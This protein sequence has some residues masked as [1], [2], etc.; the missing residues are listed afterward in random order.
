MSE[1]E[2]KPVYLTFSAHIDQF[3]VQRFFATIAGAMHD[4]FTEAH[5]LMQ[6]IGGNVADGVCLYNYFKS[7]PIEISIYNCGSISSAGVTAY[8]GGD[9]R[10][11]TP[12]GTFMIHRASAVFQGANSDAVQAR[13]PSLIMDDERTEMILRECIELTDEQ[14]SVHKA[15]DLWLNANGALDAKIATEIGSFS[16][17]YEAK[18]FNVLP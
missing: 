3:A 12:T 6:T 10:F 16:I 9:N 15:A 13:I 1:S 7:L 18:L 8:L 2:A 11:I 17:P 14:W 4:G 5:I